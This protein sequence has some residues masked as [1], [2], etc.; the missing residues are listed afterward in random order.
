MGDIKALLNLLDTMKY[1]Y[2]SITLN[3]AG[4]TYIHFSQGH[5]G[6][7]SWISIN[8]DANGIVTVEGQ[9]QHTNGIFDT[10]WNTT[11]E[12]DSS[13]YEYLKKRLA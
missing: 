7:N 13:L 8:E 2:G 9:E 4:N 6:R 11:I 10:K 1:R 5:N 3:G 12:P